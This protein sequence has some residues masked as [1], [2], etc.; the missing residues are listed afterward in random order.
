MGQPV[1]KYQAN[2]GTLHDTEAAMQFRDLV[3][4]E[5]QEIEAYI[6]ATDTWSRGEPA[7]A[8]RLIGEFLSWRRGGPWTEEGAAQ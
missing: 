4:A 7:R 2:D 6:E 5:E 1:T 3:L 8:R